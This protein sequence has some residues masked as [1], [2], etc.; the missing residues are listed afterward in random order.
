V[1]DGFRSERNF[2]LWVLRLF[3]GL[4]GKPVIKHVLKAKLYMILLRSYVMHAPFEGL[5]V[6]DDK[7][8]LEAGINTMLQIALK[9]TKKRKRGSGVQNLLQGPQD[10]NDAT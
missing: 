5:F 4:Y 1:K 7:A 3:V 10:G 9:L 8:A 6:D 2:I